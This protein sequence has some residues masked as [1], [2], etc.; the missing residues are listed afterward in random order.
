MTTT[1]VKWGNSQGI[2]LPKVFLQ[3][4]NISENDMV[5]VLIE[6][7]AIV[8]KKIYGKK[9]LTTKERLTDFYGRNIKDITKKQEEVDWGKSMGKEVW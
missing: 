6:N 1:I 9:H 4:I 2:R 8:I 3:D 7:E 5:D